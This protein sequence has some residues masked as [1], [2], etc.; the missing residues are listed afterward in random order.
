MNL[1]VAQLLLL[2]GDGCLSLGIKLPSPT[3]DMICILH[4]L[5][6]VLL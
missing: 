5:A 3:K 6:L 4:I 1:C 2:L